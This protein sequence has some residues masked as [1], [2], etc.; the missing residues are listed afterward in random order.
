M[1]M[2]II[3]RYNVIEFEQFTEPEGA[4]CD[5]HFIE[6]Y[7]HHYH[8]ISHHYDSDGNIIKNKSDILSNLLIPSLPLSTY[9]Y[10]LIST[11]ANSNNNSNSSAGSTTVTNNNTVIAS[12]ITINSPTITTTIATTTTSTTTTTNSNSTSN[13][14][15]NN[16]ITSSTTT[17]TTTT[18]SMD[19]ILDT[20]NDN[21]L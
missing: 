1:L 7:N 20:S 6:G 18:G 3:Y 21:M 19:D 10:H 15:I 8:R 5:L 9:S 11:I 14:T 2:I 13:N 17:T 16:A 12:M 4:L